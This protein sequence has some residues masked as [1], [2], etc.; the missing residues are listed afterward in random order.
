MLSGAKLS[1][2]ATRRKDLPKNFPWIVTQIPVFI[3]SIQHQE[4]NPHLKASLRSYE[5]FRVFTRATL[6]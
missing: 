1:T 6:C 4:S 2:L 5:K 3:T